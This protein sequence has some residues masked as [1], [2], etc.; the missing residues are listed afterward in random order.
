M[1]TDVRVSRVKWKKYFLLK[2]TVC[3][4]TLLYNIAWIVF[5]RNC[6]VAKYLTGIILKTNK[7]TNK[8]KQRKEDYELH[9]KNSN[10]ISF[11]LKSVACRPLHLVNEISFIVVNI[12]IIWGSQTAAKSFSGPVNERKINSNNWYLDIGISEFFLQ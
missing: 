7:Q 10:V 6:I 11:A 2:P 5:K 3:T 9:L 4:Y 1:H 12:K 8:Q